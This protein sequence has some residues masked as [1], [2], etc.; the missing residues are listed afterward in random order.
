MR[1]GRRERWSCE[2]SA[3]SVPR[4]RCRRDATG[5]RS[6]IPNA[7]P[8]SAQCRGTKVPDVQ[9]TMDDPRVM[10]TQVERTAEMTRFDRTAFAR[11]E[12]SFR[13]ELVRPGDTS[14]DLHR[15]VWNGSIDRHPALI[16]RCMG[17][18]DIIAALAFARTAGLVVAVRSGGRQ[19]PARACSGG[20]G[21]N[22][23]GLIEE[24]R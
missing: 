12:G 17:V 14:Y 4:E 2:S 6:A 19:P 23:P 7:S 10:T 22:A 8:V 1:S 18:P 24:N 16:A 13:G 20:G 5:S 15:K 11:L 21:V 9:A 3:S